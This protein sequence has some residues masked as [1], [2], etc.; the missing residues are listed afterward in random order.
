MSKIVLQGPCV[1]VVEQGEGQHAVR[2][3]EL[4]GSRPIFRDS[5]GAQRWFRP[6]ELPH[7]ERHDAMREALE[8][9]IEVYWAAT[10]GSSAVRLRDA[11]RMAGIEP[12]A[13]VRP[14]AWFGGRR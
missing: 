8:F 10:G 3:I 14:D 7:D 6:S 4:S 5:A 1:R 9:L 13:P 2:L 12:V 11:T